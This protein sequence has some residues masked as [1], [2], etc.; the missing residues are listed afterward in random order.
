MAQKKSGWSKFLDI[1]G[2]SEETDPQEERDRGYGSGSYGRQEAYEPAQR[3]KNG[4]RGDS[5]RRTS[6]NDTARKSR[7]DS[8]PRYETSSANRRRRDTEY[9]E[10]RGGRSYREWDDD[11][12]PSRR[13][14]SYADARF[15][16]DEET[17]RFVREQSK[18]RKEPPKKAE[19]E[20]CSVFS[21]Q[22][23]EDC[24]EVINRLL[25]NHTVALTMNQMDERTAE[26]SIDTLAGAVFALGASMNEISDMTYLLAP[27]NVE[28]SN[29]DKPRKKI[30]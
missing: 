29:P 7:S 22:K 13:E 11:V 20:Q 21:L 5:E 24:C 26:R 15:A 16:E 9:S 28:V 4:S 8:A 23:L 2:F 3:R 25:E 1:I 27:K 18:P 19:P 14:R 12:R 6:N 10:E 30:K 17:E